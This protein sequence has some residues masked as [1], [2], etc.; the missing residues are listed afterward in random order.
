MVLHEIVSL[1][2]LDDDGDLIRAYAVTEASFV[3]F[4]K[5]RKRT[6]P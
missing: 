5:D 1:P 6:C 4:S 3:N 2:P